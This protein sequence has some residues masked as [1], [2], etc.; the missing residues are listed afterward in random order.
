MNLSKKKNLAAKTLKAGKGRIVFAAGRLNEIKEA[1][2]K[3]D[4]LDLKNAG[5]ISIR[6]TKGRKRV[7]NLRKRSP[8]KIRKNVNKRKREYIIMTRKLR[9]HLSPLK[10]TDKISRENYKDIRK[11]IRNKFFRSKAHLK[12]YIKELE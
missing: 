11:K 8:G 10:K 3:Q 12:E 4:V 2:T 5:A 9:A 7:A 6:Q 1:I